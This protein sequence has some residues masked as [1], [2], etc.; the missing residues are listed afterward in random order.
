[1]L[2]VIHVVASASVEVGQCLL[3]FGAEYFAFQVA[4]RKYKDLGTQKYNSAY[5][6]V[7]VLN[8]V[9]YIEGGT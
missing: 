3:P 2:R 5:C 6:F 8:L 9:A 7:W 1:M 4:I